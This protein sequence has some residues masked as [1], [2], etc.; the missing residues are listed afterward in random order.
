MESDEPKI[1]EVKTESA[2]KTTEKPK[3]MLWLWIIITAIV[4]GGG[5]AAFA[6]RG[7]L[8]DRFWPKTTTVSTSDQTAAAT[9]TASA[10]ATAGTKIVDDGITWLTPREKLDDLGLFKKTGTDEAVSY[11]GTDY[12]K[13]ATTSDGNDIILAM[14]KIDGMGTSY[15]LHH[16]LKKGGVYYWLTNNSDSTSRQGDYYSRANSQVDSKFVIKSLQQDASFSKGATKLTQDTYASRSQSFAD[17]TTAGDKIEETKWG[18]LYLLKGSNI[19]EKS[20]EIK[21]ARYY[22]LRND[23]IKIVYHPDVTYRNDDGTL[24]ISWTNPA[25][26][27]QKFSQIHTSGCGSGGGSFPLIANA[28]S[29]STKIEVGSVSGNKVYTMPANS[30]LAGLAY[31]V[32][33]MDGLGDKVTKNAMMSDLGLIVLQDGYGNWLAYMND[34]YAPAVECGKPVIYLYPEKSTQISV[35]VGADITKSEPAY[36]G[37]WN[38]LASK[39]GV[40]KSK[41]GIFPYLFWEGTGWGEYPQI[42]SGSIVKSSDVG[43]TIANQLNTIGLND[44]EINDF[45]DFWLPKMPA[46]AYV[47]LTWL[48]NDQM[49]KLAPLQVS[50]KPETSIR[51]FLDF[52]GVNAPYSI[53]KQTLPHIERKGFTLVEWGGLLRR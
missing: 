48:L 36:N 35:K 13:V 19:T 45:K 43:S 15:D 37:G 23:G 40:L 11:L 28:T 42:S 5:T 27:D 17:S 3:N 1:D 21:V 18:D 14:V 29:V 16:F 7:D 31:Q 41:D 25:G 10:S 2:A 52:T 38:V 46:T 12:Y 24:D 8:K 22:I 51:V 26:K 50:P 49:D 32:Y 47:R 9:A 6:Y 39:D 53:E 44:K 34:K 33:T 4:V 20:E 30:T